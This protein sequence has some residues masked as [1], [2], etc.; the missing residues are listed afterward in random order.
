VFTSAASDD[1]NFHS[2]LT[3]VG[4]PQTVNPGT[5]PAQAR[6]LRG[7]ELWQRGNFCL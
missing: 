4:A 2:K 5:L 1:E 3:I 6:P 7:K